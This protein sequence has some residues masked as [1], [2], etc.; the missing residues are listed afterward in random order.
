MQYSKSKSYIDLK[1]KSVLEL[2]HQQMNFCF[3]ILVVLTSYFVFGSNYN[4]VMIY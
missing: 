3:M 2:V 1:R 4:K